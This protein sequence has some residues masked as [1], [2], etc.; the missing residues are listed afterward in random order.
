MAGFHDFGCNGRW[1]LAAHHGFLGQVM[2]AVSGFYR[3]AADEVDLFLLEH[4]VDASRRGVLQFVDERFAH[5]LTVFLPSL[6]AAPVDV[7][8][9]VAGHRFRP[10]GDQVSVPAQGFLQAVQ[11]VGPRQVV[12]LAAHQHVDLAGHLEQTA[13]VV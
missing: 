7:G 2:D 9:H 8:H 3:Q 4:G 5:V 1:P 12:H 13:S 6:Q 10:G 11:A